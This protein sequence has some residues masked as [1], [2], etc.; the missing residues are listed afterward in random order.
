MSEDIKKDIKAIHKS[1]NRMI[2]YVCS[3]VV[4]CTLIDIY[5]F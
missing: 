5:L 3:T 1:I 2:V 4:V